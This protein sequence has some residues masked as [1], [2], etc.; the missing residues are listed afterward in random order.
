MEEISQA[1][2]KRKVIALD[3]EGTLIA[4]ASNCRPRPGLYS[5]LEWCK[6]HFNQVVIYT[7]V[8]EVEFRLIADSLA[9]NNLAPAWFKY[10]AYIE[11]D[12]MIKD[13]YNIEGI[14][15]QQAIIVDDAEIFIS[16]AQKEQWVEIKPFDYPY[17][18]GD[19]EFA[20]V[21]DVIE[22]KY[23]NNSV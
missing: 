19:D 13:L 18:A 3:L 23:F 8:D 6:S 21:M 12:G 2:T 22:N 10:I 4:S 16:D 11:W 15:P 7:C 5:F 14:K 20:R 9:E 17:A 1:G